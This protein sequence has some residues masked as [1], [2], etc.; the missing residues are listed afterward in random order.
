MLTLYQPGEGEIKYDKLTSPWA[1]HLAFH[2]GR[3]E[4][5]V[6]LLNIFLGWFLARDVR[7]FELRKESI[8]GFR[9]K[10]WVF[11]Q[12]PLDHQCLYNIT[13]GNASD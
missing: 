9:G 12:L 5:S 10:S 7:F 2:L 3:G 13:V 11:H 1:A 6:L 4:R 8:P